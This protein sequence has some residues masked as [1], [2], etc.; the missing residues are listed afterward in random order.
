MQLEWIFENDAVPHVLTFITQIFNTILTTS[1]YPQMWKISKIMLV[2]TS[3]PIVL[4][5]YRP[6]IL[7]A[8]FKALDIIE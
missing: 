6:I 7:P 5:D 1:S 4:A 8:L 2:K 3:E